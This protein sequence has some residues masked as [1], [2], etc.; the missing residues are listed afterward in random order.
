MQQQ[1]VVTSSSWVLLMWVENKR[2]EK[3]LLLCPA[4]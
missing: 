3:W 1:E 2:Q 4:S